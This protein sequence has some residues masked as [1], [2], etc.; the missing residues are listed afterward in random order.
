[1]QRAAREHAA[2]A[3]PAVTC[4]RF[5]PPRLRPFRSRLVCRA[6]A[7]VLASAFGLTAAAPAGA[8][9]ARAETLRTVLDDVRAVD[10][11]WAAARDAPSADRRAAFAAAYAEAAADGT[12]AEAV[13]RLLSADSMSGVL[14]PAVERAVAQA[15]GPSPA[16][17]LCAMLLPGSSPLAAPVAVRP[18]AERADVASA[19]ERA[20]NGRPRAP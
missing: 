3:P 9:T 8:R 2:G 19:G 20:P 18:G 11:A 12:T 6:L 1:M 13:E 4:V 17:S 16:P 15:A 7:L 5:S 10:A 14:P